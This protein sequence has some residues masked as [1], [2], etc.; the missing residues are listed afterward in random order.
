MP[1]N[2]KLHTSNI[3]AV[4]RMEEKKKI[5]GKRRKEGGR[6]EERGEGKRGGVYT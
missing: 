1:D 4:E 5:K 3:A 2:A 6:K